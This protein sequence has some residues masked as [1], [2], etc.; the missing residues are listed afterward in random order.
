MLRLSVLVSLLGLSLAHEIYPGRCPDFNPMKGFDWAKFS[1]GIWY[2][3]QKFDTKSSCLTYQFKTDNLGFKSVEQIRQLPFKDAVGVD[4]DYKYTGKLYAP[5][6][7]VPSKMEVRFPL[8][9]LGSASYVVTDTDYDTYGMVC[10]C[11]DVD[12][13]ITFAHRISCS[14][15]Q[16]NPTE[17]P[18][19][20]KKLKDSVEEKY[21]H[22]F[23]KIDQEGCEYAR[24]K[25][26]SIDVDKIIGKVGGAD[27]TDTD[28]YDFELLNPD[29]IAEIAGDI[30][31]QLEGSKLTL[32]DL[33]E[34]AKE[35]DII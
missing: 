10:T 22:D 14:I 30:S 32:D 34:K 15:L 6:E 12:L 21:T 24:E 26:W 1:E 28:Y 8:N 7:A 17:D 27:Q 25:A 18:E 3:T 31:S 13:Y 9:A 23:D 33:K 4:H 35:Q 16:R 20:T 11:Q 2:V 19:I 29:E 5:Q